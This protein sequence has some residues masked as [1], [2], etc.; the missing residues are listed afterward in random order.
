MQ[1][2]QPRVKF[3]EYWRLVKTQ[4]GGPPF[5]YHCSYLVGWINTTALN[6]RGVIESASSLLGQNR[7]AWNSS[8]SYKLL[9]SQLSGMPA[10]RH[11]KKIVCFGLGDICRK[12]PD[13][14]LRNSALDEHDV[15]ASFV[16]QSM[17]QH[18]IALTL[19]GLCYTI[20]GNYVQLLVQDPDYTEDSKAILSREGFNI[21]GEHGAGGLAE[22]DDNTLVFSA[23]VE[24]PLK[25][26]IADIARPPIIISTG[27]DTFN[28]S[29]YVFASTSPKKIY[30]KL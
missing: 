30:S 11:V 18:S 14:L 23:F 7:L 10:L 5:T 1:P 17:V 24:A 4:P 20:A 8:H 12:P 6:F 13:W 25:Q 28:D 21:V 2:R 9:K 3:Q 22:I 16:R 26:I 29:E 15:C 27:F 19:A